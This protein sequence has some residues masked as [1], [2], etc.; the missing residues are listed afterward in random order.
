MLGNDLF[1]LS[2]DYGADPRLTD[3]LTYGADGAAIMAAPASSRKLMRKPSVLG[4]L[5]GK[6]KGLMGDGEW[7]DGSPVAE[8]QALGALSGGASVI[9][10]LF[11]MGQREQEQQR[12]YA[13]DELALADQMYQDRR[14][15]MGQ[16]TA[17]NSVAVR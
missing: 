10:N 15:R 4:S 6:A 12:G 17:L 8:G 1:N 3:P 13:A 16:T 14:R 5:W 7:G 2:R 11:D 9:G